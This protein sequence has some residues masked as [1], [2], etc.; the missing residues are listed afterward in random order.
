MTKNPAIN[1]VLGL[2]GCD[3]H[4]TFCRRLCPNATLVPNESAKSSH[5]GLGVTRDGILLRPVAQ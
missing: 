3:G 2:S 5:L 4:A 1:L